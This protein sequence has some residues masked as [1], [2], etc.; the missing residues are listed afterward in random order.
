MV[1]YGYCPKCKS[2]VT[3][4]TPTGDNG[5]CYGCHCGFCF[6]DLILPTD[7]QLDEWDSE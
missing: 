4:V 5:E 1:I 3:E 2:E 7:S 6:D